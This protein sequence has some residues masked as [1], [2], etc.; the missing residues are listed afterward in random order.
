MAHLSTIGNGAPWRP[1]AP[2]SLSSHDGRSAAGAPRTRGTASGAGSFE[3]EPW[4]IALPGLVN[5]LT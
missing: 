3:A 1:A 2:G 5:G 4:R